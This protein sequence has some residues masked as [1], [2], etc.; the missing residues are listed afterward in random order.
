MKPFCWIFILSVAIVSP[1][2]GNLYPFSIFPMFSD[3]AS[4]HVVIEI[5][6]IDGNRLST[7]DYGLTVLLLANHSGRY[8]L[9]RGPC[10]FEEHPEMQVEE[11]REFLASNFPDQPYPIVIRHWVRGFD[12]E[13]RTIQNLTEVAEFQ[14]DPTSVAKAPDETQPSNPKTFSN[15]PSTDSSND[16]AK[17]QQGAIR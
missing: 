3:N 1:I 13:T 7:D 5:E 15:T 2:F 4:Q 17:N 9:K 10:Y 14:I 8:G 6:D 11:V 16:Q 12:Q